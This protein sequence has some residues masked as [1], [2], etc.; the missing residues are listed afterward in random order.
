MEIEIASY[1]SRSS[2]KAEY[3]VL[4]SITS[5]LMLISQLLTDLRIKFLLPTTVFCDYQ[6]TIAITSNPIFHEQTKH[7]KIDNHFV[8]DK[9]IHGFLKVIS[10]CSSLQLVDKVHQGFTIYCIDKTLTQVRN[11]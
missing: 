1:V 5:E 2:T 6:A 10:I 8:R 7:I 11:C 3:R 9:M 4:A